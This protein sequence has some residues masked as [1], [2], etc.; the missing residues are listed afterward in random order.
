MNY[1]I[2]KIV[3]KDETVPGVYVGSSKNFV[4]RQY[5]H[6]QDSNDETK[7]SKLYK[8]VRAN[9]GIHNW[10]F[11]V[12]E[13][14]TCDTTTDARIRERYYVDEFEADLNTNRPH[15]NR[16]EAKEANK[17]YYENNKLKHAENSKAYQMCNRESISA[18]K[19]EYRMN[20]KES[21]AENMKQYNVDNHV[22]LTEYRKQFYLDNTEIA[23]E[24][25]KQYRLD[26]AEK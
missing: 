8:T 9:G 12:I 2:Y 22:R 24:K 6:K 20:N 23:V 10:E 21:I 13:Y 18:K 17:Q 15:I 11:I 4:R 3:C 26:N 16:E 19:K 5:K 1:T 14:C 25:G 7:T